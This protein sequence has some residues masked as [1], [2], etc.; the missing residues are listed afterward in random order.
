MSRS[1]LDVDHEA[2]VQI[3][4]IQRSRPAWALLTAG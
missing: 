2:I 4:D 3:G 1:G